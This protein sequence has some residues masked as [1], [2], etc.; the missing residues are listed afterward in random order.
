MIIDSPPPATADM[1]AMTYAPSTNKTNH[2]GQQRS[3]NIIPWDTWHRSFSPMTARYITYTRKSTM[4]DIREHHYA[5]APTLTGSITSHLINHQEIVLLDAT[6]DDPSKVES[7]LTECIPIQKNQRFQDG[8]IGIGLGR[9]L[10]CI[11]LLAITAPIDERD[12][13]LDWF[14]TLVRFIVGLQQNTQSHRWFDVILTTLRTNDAIEDILVMKLLQAALGVRTIPRIREFRWFE[15]SIEKAFG[16]NPEL[17]H[18]VLTP[19]VWIVVWNMLHADMP[20]GQSVSSAFDLLQ[21]QVGWTDSDVMRTLLGVMFPEIV[22]HTDA[23]LDSIRKKQRFGLEHTPI[24]LSDGTTIPPRME[25]LPMGIACIGSSIDMCRHTSAETILR[26]AVNEYNIYTPF[27]MDRTINTTII[28][29]GTPISPDHVSKHGAGVLFRGLHIPPLTTDAFRGIMGLSLAGGRGDGR[30]KPT[31]EQI[32]APVLAETASSELAVVK[33]TQREYRVRTVG[34]S[35]DLVMPFRM[36]DKIFAIFFKGIRDIEI[37]I[38][39]DTGRPPVYGGRTASFNQIRSP[40]NHLQS[41]A[42]L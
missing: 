18:N 40:F 42:Q 11:L 3:F 26:F 19:L 30:T 5:F 20:F 37:R 14:E 31:D 28:I 8:I 36:A 27:Y 34:W 25:K 22:D 10:K 16:Y 1:V 23:I 9:W 32:P 38:R 4:T 13:Y 29:T 2:C 15:K 24:R 12:R 17:R 35:S 21:G 6:W 33:M 41:T 39:R 7:F